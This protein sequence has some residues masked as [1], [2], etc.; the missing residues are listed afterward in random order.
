MLGC[1][2]DLPFRAGHVLFPACY[3]EHRLLAPHR[4]LDVSVGL[5]SERF[6]FTTCKQKENEYELKKNAIFRPE[7]GLRENRRDAHRFNESYKRVT[8]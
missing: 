1:R 7:S 6:D 5:R 2:E 3:H 8:S 4:G